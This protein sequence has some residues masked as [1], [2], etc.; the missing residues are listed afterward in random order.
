MKEFLEPI[1]F[2]MANRSS[3]TLWTF[4]TLQKFTPLKVECTWLL[5]V[6]PKLF[7]SKKNNIRLIKREFWK[8][9]WKFFMD[10]W[11]VY[12]FLSGVGQTLNHY[13]SGTWNNQKL[14]LSMLGYP[15]N[16]PGESPPW[17]P[18]P[19]ES[20]QVNYRDIRISESPDCMWAG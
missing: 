9:I 4:I 13:I 20:T 19:G 7:K 11:K 2:I 10:F 16:P 6:P 5:Q 1:I 3:Y 8:P 15:E 14:V 17:I 18:T 12:N